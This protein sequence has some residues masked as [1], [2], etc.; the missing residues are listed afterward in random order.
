M[1]DKFTAEEVLRVF[2][3]ELDDVRERLDV[4]QRARA[5]DEAE[6]ARVVAAVRKHAESLARTLDKL[7]PLS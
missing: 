1:T 5:E 3:L 6:R 7:E 2:G 4:Y